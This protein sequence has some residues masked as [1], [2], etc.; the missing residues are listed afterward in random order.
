MS[1]SFMDAIRGVVTEGAKEKTADGMTKDAKHFV[2]DLHK[3]QDS[4]MKHLVQKDSET[5]DYEKMFSGD[6]DRAPSNRGSYA[7]G[8]DLDKYVEY[9]EHLEIEEAKKKA[10]KHDD[11]CECDDCSSEEDVKEEVVNEAGAPRPNPEQRAALDTRLASQAK[12]KAAGPSP[13]PQ[14][15][16]KPAGLFGA[17]TKMQQATQAASSMGAQRAAAAKSAAGTAARTGSSVSA[18]LPSDQKLDKGRLGVTATQRVNAGQLAKTQSPAASKPYTTADK[19]VNDRN[20]RVMALR[21]KTAPSIAAD[22]KAAG[23]QVQGPQKPAPANLSKAQAITQ[24]Y[25]DKKKAEINKSVQLQKG[26]EARRGSDLTGPSSAPRPVV[27]K[28][29]KDY[30]LG[31]AKPKPDARGTQDVKI[32]PTSG[33]PP[34]QSPVDPK[35]SNAK[36]ALDPAKTAPKSK[37]KPTT[38]QKTKQTPAAP[39]ASSAQKREARRKLDKGAVGPEANRLQTGLGVTFKK[40]P[41]TGIAATKQGIEGK[42]Q[43]YK[44]GSTKKKLNQSFEIDIAGTSYLVSEAHASA[45]AAFV[46]KYGAVNEAGVGEFISKEMKHPEKLTAK[47]KKQKIKQAIAIF[48]SKKRRGENS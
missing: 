3:V 6:V 26:A 21:G 44:P 1:K 7:P 42:L 18:P 14:S 33:P 17:T 2:D 38:P 46:E 9:N 22:Q 11:D 27:N 32:V 19:G 24:G 39:P 25:A 28:F 35:S 4:G 40:D 20:A 47:G 23:K 16:V 30:G 29:R 12:M 5:K 41:K 13:M 36:S 37:I 34:A 15:G 43:Q 48:Y 31:I 45:I 8:E 10:E